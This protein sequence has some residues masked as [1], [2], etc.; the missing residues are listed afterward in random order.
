MI[1]RL[2]HKISIATFNLHVVHI[3][4]PYKTLHKLFEMLVLLL[5]ASIA[6]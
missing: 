4:D 6:R 5:K 2:S 3:F 1:G